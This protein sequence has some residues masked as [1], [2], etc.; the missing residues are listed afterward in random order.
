MWR[1]GRRASALRGGGDR[2]ALHVV[3]DDAYRAFRDVC[4]GK[5]GE[6]MSLPL[7]GCDMTLGTRLRCDD[8]VPGGGLERGLVLER[9]VAAHAGDDPACHVCCLEAER[10]APCH[11]VDEGNRC[12]DERGDLEKHRGG[13][14]LLERG[15]VDVPLVPALV[16]LFACEVEP[17]GAA[18]VEEIDVQVLQGVI[19][20]GFRVTIEEMAALWPP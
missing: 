10:A 18:V 16:E 11:R 13:D 12:G 3:A 2:A 14:G 15:V 1:D 7:R 8:V 5:G 19:A 20:F 9:E 4:G 17:E 6:W